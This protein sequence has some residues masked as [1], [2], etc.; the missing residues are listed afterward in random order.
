MPLTG[1]AVIRRGV[2]SPPESRRHWDRGGR[3]DRRAI[4]SARSAGARVSF[5]L[6]YR[7]KLWTESEAQRVVDHC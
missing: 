6:N 5:D 7:R 3:R 4:G 2:V 1:Q